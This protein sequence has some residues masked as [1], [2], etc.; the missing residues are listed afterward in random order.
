MKK[1]ILKS[2]LG[3]VV[4]LALCMMTSCEK[5]EEITNPTKYGRIQGIVTNLNTSEPIQGVNIS[6]SPTGASAVTGSDGRY[7]FANLEPGLYSVQGMK[8]GFE[9]NT[10]TITIVEDQVSSGDMMLKPVVS[11]FTLNVDYLDFGTSFNTLTFKIINASASLPLSW[12]ISESLNW[13]STNPTT[14]NLMGGQEATVSVS[15]DRTL[16]NQ[17]TTANITV[18]TA[19]QSVILPVSVR[20]W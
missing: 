16:I 12:E 18:R 17:N 5:V 3:A 1:S 10:K 6:L 7:E 8:S 2:A 11:G 14:G 4:A 9:T 19:D 20:V 15:V 13:L